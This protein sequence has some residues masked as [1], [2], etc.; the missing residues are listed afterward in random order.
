MSTGERCDVAR[1]AAQ[2][3]YIL[4]IVVRKGS[5]TES[6][7]RQTMYLDTASFSQKNQKY[8]LQFKSLCGLERSNILARPQF[9]HDNLSNGY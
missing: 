9:G 3:S 5:W 6:P 1:P 8:V 4:R 7:A 2:C